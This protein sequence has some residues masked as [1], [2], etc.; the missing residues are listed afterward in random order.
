MKPLRD[1][2]ACCRGARQ[3]QR[4]LSQTHVT[5][6]HKRRF[7]WSADPAQVRFQARPTCVTGPCWNE[8]SARLAVKDCRQRD[9]D[10]PVGKVQKSWLHS[11]Q[12]RGASNCSNHPQRSVTTCVA[13]ILCRF[14]F[15]SHVRPSHFSPMTST[16]KTQLMRPRRE[17]KRGL[18]FSWRNI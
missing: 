6:E 4:A 5:M 8:R 18:C 15:L 9:G 3:R 10:Q 12:Q 14:P 17:S 7:T 16:L 2:E 1:H 11:Q 13:R